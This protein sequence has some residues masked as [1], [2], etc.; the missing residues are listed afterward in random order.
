MRTMVPAIAKKI[1]GVILSEIT[2]PAI[3]GLEEILLKDKNKREQTIKIVSETAFVLHMTK[4][5]FKE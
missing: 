5:N 1:H 2:G 4:K 3:I